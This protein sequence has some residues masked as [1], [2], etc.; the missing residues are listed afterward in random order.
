[1]LI[2][3][4]GLGVRKASTAA[5]NGARKSA[6]LRAAGGGR[7]HVATSDREYTGQEMEFLGA[8]ESYKSRTGKKFPTWTEVLGVITELG[9]VQPM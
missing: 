1:M 9:Y 8:I 7:K 6:A 3:N 4:D 2:E 5:L